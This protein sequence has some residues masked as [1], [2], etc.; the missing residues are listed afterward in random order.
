MHGAI[1][2]AHKAAMPQI[3]Q[4]FK[5]GIFLAFLVFHALELCTDGVGSHQLASFLNAA[6]GST[7]QRCTTERNICH[8]RLSQQNQATYYEFW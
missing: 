4:N 2:I 3:L 1:A 6:A 7:G 5:D 8:G